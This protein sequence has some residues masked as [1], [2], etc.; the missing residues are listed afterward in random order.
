[1]HTYD[2]ATGIFSITLKIDWVT[3]KAEPSKQYHMWCM[4][5]LLFRNY[6]KGFQ[7]NVMMYTSKEALFTLSVISNA[8]N[9]NRNNADTCKV[10][11]INN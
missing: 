3:Q 4:V 5:G 11:Y 1:M 6:S 9:L 10:Q 2:A 8:Q 7:T